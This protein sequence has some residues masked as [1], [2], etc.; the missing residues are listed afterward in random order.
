MSQ[1]VPRVDRLCW[2][3]CSY[4]CPQTW[5]DEIEGRTNIDLSPAMGFLNEN[6]SLTYF[7]ILGELLSGLSFT[8]GF[9]QDLKFYLIISWLLQGAKKDMPH[10]IL[11]F[12][13]LKKTKY[14]KRIFFNFLH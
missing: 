11:M 13:W 5:L 7:A 3:T 4:F 8:V 6:D 2:E 14:L 10:N 12:S 1:S 9:F